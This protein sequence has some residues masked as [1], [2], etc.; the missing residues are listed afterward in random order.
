MF[1]KNIFKK[2][3]I[4]NPDY[5]STLNNNSVREFDK[6]ITLLVISD[7]HGDLA[8]NKEMQKKLL[9]KKYDLC[10]ILGDIHDYDY[11]VILK[12][13]PK[14]KIISILGNHDRFSLLNEHGL[15][16]YNGKVVN[17]N[18]IRIGLIQ[19]SFKYKDENF[20]S[21]TH[22]ESIEFL[23]KMPRG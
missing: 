14:E 15:D 5:E 9:N 19:G 10:C 2:E 6:N 3:K 8:L 12:H 18:G 4:Y 23:D 7:T 22:E 11:E 16:D 20:P 13:I 17:I 1:F 21:F